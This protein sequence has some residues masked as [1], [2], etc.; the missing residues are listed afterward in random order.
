MGL[1][2][3]IQAICLIEKA[4][5][6]LLLDIVKSNNFLHAFQEYDLSGIEPFQLL[7]FCEKKL[8][9]LLW[10]GSGKHEILL[11]ENKNYLLSSKTLY[12][13]I[14]ENAREKDFRRFQHKNIDAHEILNFHRKHQ[15]EKEPGIDAA[16]KEEFLTVSITQL[17]IRQDKIHFA[18]HDLTENTIQHK[19]IEKRSL[20]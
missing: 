3:N 6:S 11:D 17:I 8:T 7:V 18:Y 9:R 19:E 2:K 20:V 4:E 5:A 13:D 12:N 16:V 14:I 15:I 10:D 1:S